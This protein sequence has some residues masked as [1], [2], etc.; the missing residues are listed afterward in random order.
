MDAQGSGR[1]SLIA[2]D[3][4]STDGCFAV[5]TVTGFYLLDLPGRRL[6]R[7][8][9]T[10]HSTSGWSMRWTFDLDGLWLPLVQLVQCVVGEPMRAQVMTG[11][12]IALEQPLRSSPVQAIHPA[13]GRVSDT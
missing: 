13:P 1:E 4:A 8:P 12:P 5:S 9:A 7:S 11:D 2:L 10:V 6:M 3:P